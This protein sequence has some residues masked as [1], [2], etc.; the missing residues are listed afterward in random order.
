MNRI[1]YSRGVRL[2]PGVQV[3]PAVMVALGAIL[4]KG[5]VLAFDTAREFPD[6]GGLSVLVENDL[7]PLVRSGVLEIDWK[8]NHVGHYTFTANSSRSPKYAAGPAK[9]PAD[10]APAKSAQGRTGDELLTELRRLRDRLNSGDE[11]RDDPDAFLARFEELD[12]FL[13]AGGQKP[14][15]WSGGA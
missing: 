11:D 8:A 3:P 5:R 7:G 6:A 10:P 4:T 9:R 2:R 1:T 15:A 14:S 13:S 12:A